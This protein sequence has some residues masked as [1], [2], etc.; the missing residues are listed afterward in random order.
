M[1]AM[2]VNHN[3]NN[4]D[5]LERICWKGVLIAER[6]PNRLLWASRSERSGVWGGSCLTASMVNPGSSRKYLSSNLHGASQ[7]QCHGLESLG[8]SSLNLPWPMTPYLDKNIKNTGWLD[9]HCRAWYARVF[10]IKEE[11]Y[12]KVVSFRCP[13]WRTR[14]VMKRLLPVPI[15]I[16]VRQEAFST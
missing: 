16:P 7:I 3:K 5:W 14:Q 15:S 2:E 11:V 4:S 6:S 12:G 1:R 13:R 10:P 8:T 9:N